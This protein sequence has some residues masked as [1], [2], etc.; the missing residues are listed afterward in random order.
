VLRGGQ[1]SR[2]PGGKAQKRGT[3]SATMSSLSGVEG[4]TYKWRFP[5]HAG[6]AFL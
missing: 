5:L 1:K 6:D 4:L 3:G 2:P